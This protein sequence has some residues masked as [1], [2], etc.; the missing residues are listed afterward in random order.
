MEV[1]SHLVA[2]DELKLLVT[3]CLGLFV[4][5]TTPD[6]LRAFHYHLDDWLL[7]ESWEV[8]YLEH[9]LLP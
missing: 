7:W 1:E 4:C 2:Y 6:H 5:A 8:R 9:T 3:S